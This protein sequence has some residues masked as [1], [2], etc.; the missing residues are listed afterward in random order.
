MFRSLLIAVLAGIMFN[1]AAQTIDH[2]QGQVIIQVSENSAIESIVKDLEFFHGQPTELRAKELLSEYMRAWLL[3][4]STES[5]DESLMLKEL[6]MHPSIQ[7]AQYN[8]IV[9]LRETTPDD[10][11]FDDQWHHVNGNDS[12]IDSDLAWDITT[13]GTTALGDEIVVCVIEGGNLLHPDLEANRWIN[14]NEIPDNGIDDDENGY[15]DDYDGWNVDSQDDSGV[16][17]GGHGT[18]VAGMI[19]AVGNNGEGVAGVNWNVKIMS[20]A[21]ENI[22]DEASVIE[23]YNYPLTQRMLYEETGG[24]KGAFVVST[25]ASWGIDNG[26]PDDVPIW[27]AFY[28]ALGENGILNCG[29]T[30]NNNVNI[31]V[32]GDIPTA[33]SSPY[34]VS[35]TATNSND[36]RTF[37]AYG[38]TTVDLGA[39]GESVW[40]TSG[41]NGYTST[42]GTSFASPLTAGAIALLYA[43]PCPSLISIAHSSPQTGADLVLAALYEGVD[44]VAN[45]ENET[46]TGGRLNVFNSLNIL[47][48][49]CSSSDCLVPFSI[50]ANSE[51]GVLYDISWS[52][53]ASMLTYNFRYREVGAVD[54]I[55]SLGL[56]ET[57]FTLDNLTWCSDYEFQVSA[58]CSD[59][60]SDWS[61]SY[62]IATNGCCEAPAME[63]MVIVELTDVSV[64]V[65]WPS[66]LAATSYEVILTDEN[67]TVTLF[68]DITENG[69][70]IGD[71]NPCAVYSLMVQSN[72]ADETDSGYSEE[73]VFGT[74]GCGSCVDNT[75][76]ASFGNVEDEYIGR[77]VLSSIDNESGAGNG[78]S[79]FTAISATLERN[80][81]YTIIL[82]PEFTGQTYLEYFRVWLDM[83]QDGEFTDDEIIFES[84]DGSADEVQGTINLAANTPLGNTRLRVSMAYAGGFFFNPQGPCVELNYGEVEDYC[85][86]VEEQIISVNETDALSQSVFPNPSN[87]EFNFN[88]KVADSYSLDI[89]DN[90]GRKIDSYNFQ[91]LNYRLNLSGYSDGFYIYRLAN[92]SGQLGNGKLLI[93]K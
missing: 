93:N 72:C 4:F 26:N 63:S 52:G 66:V 12:D 44:P 8:H 78:Y 55:E 67:G 18:N 80:T 90:N 73:L 30:A 86:N 92:K 71:L 28:D 56:T 3:E 2:V 21:G 27:C 10:L 83:S 64:I 29:A 13:G 50:S 16:F 45:L 61:N 68:S 89:F 17:Q 87:G 60:S 49:N 36:V 35:V 43:V 76:C 31:D 75:Y 19:G 41:T 7:V 46:V 15:V 74:F 84:E 53:L 82:T 39:P 9:K 58:D 48:E 22:F 65:E 91:G 34:M 1:S 6:R 24:A 11:N 42:S 32:V 38:A 25:N 57:T 85:I 70:E 37:S 81:D 47:L 33:C 62:Y 51:D 54:W 14:L 69:I 23:A 40:T 88:M 20:V 5:I 77:V 59:E 79:D